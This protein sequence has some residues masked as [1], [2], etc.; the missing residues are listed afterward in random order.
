MG[1]TALP[2]HDALLPQA[3]GGNGPGAALALLVHL[4]LI[5]ALT[6]VVDWR[7]RT[8]ETM[9]AELWAAVPQVAA[10]PPPVPQVTPPPPPP[11]PAP[12]AEAPLPREADIALEKARERKAEQERQRAEEAAK[13]AETERKRLLAQ[14]K[15]D[16]RKKQLEED[17]RR[18]EADRKKT[19]EAQKLQ[20]EREAQET[21][22]EEART[23]QQREANLRRMM[24]QA[25]GSAGSTG[26]AAHNAGPSG[27]YAGKLISA[28]RRNI[29]FTGA[30]TGNPVATVEV[31]AAPGGSIIS[32][33]L[34]KSSGHKDWDDAVLRAVERT[35][36][37]PRDTD[38][39]VPSPVTID[40]SF[41]D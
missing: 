8:P 17:K 7:V 19:A 25:G 31:T 10:P 18:Q 36:S 40:F 16:E 20:R 37:L 9:S 4:G 23:A 14:Q 3:P 35:G 22:A 5:L 2:A 13:A 15:A 12:R 33:R 30:P 24:G 6:T 21:K 29:V 27:T 32:R 41:R 26:T 34:V 39:R 38:G 11:A 28:I 1:A